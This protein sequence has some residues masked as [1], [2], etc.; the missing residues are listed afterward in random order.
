MR[1]ERDLLS[2]MHH[3]QQELVRARLALL[4][5][6]DAAR[7]QPFFL[8]P[9]KRDT[10][11]LREAIPSLVSSVLE[12]GQ[13]REIQLSPAPVFVLP[14]RA[15]N[16]VNILSALLTNAL[17]HGCAPVR[18]R[19]AVKCGGGTLEVENSG[20]DQPET[21]PKSGCSGLG[22]RIVSVLVEAGMLRRFLSEE[23]RGR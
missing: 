17:P 4:E 16:F 23:K 1:V 13:Q 14:P 21:R 2:A 15:E 11:Y 8:T 3:R 22:L 12:P 18:S 19:I 20:P 5:V 6:S 9:G 10:V 7:L